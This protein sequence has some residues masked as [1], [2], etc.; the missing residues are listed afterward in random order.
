[1]TQVSVEYHDEQLDFEVPEP[2]IV[3]VWRGPAGLGPREQLSALVHGLEN[4][5]NFPPLRQAVVPGDRVVIAWDPTIG[6]AGPVLETLAELFKAAGVEDGD[7]TVL[8]P[9]RGRENLVEVLLQGTKVIVHDPDDRSQLAY[10]ATTKQGRRVYLN[11]LL[12]DA[13]LVVPVGRLGF[14]SQ[15]WVIADR[16]ACFFPR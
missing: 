2:S 4:P 8:T 10:L 1:M 9:P 6:E 13:D 16:G 11:R 12:T 14:D 15:S 3:G 7:L 5:R